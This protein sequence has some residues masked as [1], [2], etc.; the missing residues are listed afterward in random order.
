MH[1]VPLILIF[2]YNRLSFL[3]HYPLSVFNRLSFTDMLS[4]IRVNRLLFAIG[5]RFQSFF[6]S[7]NVI[8]TF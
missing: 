7:L 1:G 8:K 5:Y 2:N 6:E 4:V 3:F